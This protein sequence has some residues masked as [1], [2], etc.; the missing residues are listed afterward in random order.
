MTSDGTYYTFFLGYMDVFMVKGTISYANSMHIVPFSINVSNFLE[1]ICQR[2]SK[3]R[4]VIL[5]ENRSFMTKNVAP[6]E[7][8]N[9]SFL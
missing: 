8:S 6:S 2:I 3:Y 4:Y 1:K 9:D 5:F 7:G